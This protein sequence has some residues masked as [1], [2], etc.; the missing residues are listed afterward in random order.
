V[1]PARQDVPRPAN[2]P[3]AFPGGGSILWAWRP[4]IPRSPIARPTSAP[5]STSCELDRDVPRGDRSRWVD[6]APT[7]QRQARLDECRPC[8]QGGAGALAT[9]RRPAAARPVPRWPQRG[10]ALG[11][12]LLDRL[13]PKSWPKVSPPR[14][15][16]RY[17]RAADWSD[18]A[19][20]RITAIG[21]EA[22]EEYLSFV[23]VR[24]P[25][26]GDRPIAE[27]ERSEINDLLD[28]I[29]DENG[30]RMA[31]VTLGYLGRVMNW[32]AAR[33]DDFRSPL[34]RG[35]ARGIAVKRDR[36]LDDE[37]L[38]AFWR[39]GKTW[40]HPFSLMLRFVLLTATRRDE[41]ADMQ[42]SELAW[43]EALGG[44]LWT[45]RAERYKTKIEHEVPLSGAA[46]DVLTA[47]S[48]PVALR[49]AAVE[50]EALPSEARKQGEVIPKQG[51]V[52]TT[53]GATGLGG[54]GKFKRTFDALT[55]AELRAAAAE[56]GEDPKNVM[57]PRWTIHDLRRTARSLMTRAGVAPDHA[58][59]CLG[60]VI[61]GVRGVY[62]RHAFSRE[63]RDAF[64]AL[65]AQI[66]CILNPTDNVVPLRGKTVG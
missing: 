35:M 38:R 24:E 52:F 13:P 64:E 56:R 25:K 20:L 50:R 48:I 66:E 33:S 49:K 41:A 54:F 32:Y 59:R 58:E 22:V 30:P 3:R 4:L 26:L 40:D 23:V 36:V 9:P 21:R 53:N 60:H 47:A 7:L 45:I 18:V 28:K 62:D 6:G 44:Y 8:W 39:A 51:F 2:A 65:A 15:R 1:R 37:E 16:R 14:S 31:T 11:L 63:K 61:G 42:W 43:T 5:S 55:L 34:V 17:G 19:R 27:I 46:W 57:L 10:A 12:R 29:E